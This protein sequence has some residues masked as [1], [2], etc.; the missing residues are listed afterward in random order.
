[1]TGIRV[2]R[3]GLMDTVQDAGRF[4]YYSLGVPDSGAADS[5]SLRAGNRILGNADSDAAI[6]LTLTGG[7]YEFDGDAD[8][9]LAGASM[10]AQVI[11]A[12]G[13]SRA[14]ELATHTKVH[15]GE[16]IRFAPATAGCRAYLCVR[17]GLDVPIVMGSRSTCLPGG[18]GGHEGRPLRAGD[19]LTIGNRAPGPLHLTTTDRAKAW[20]NERFQKR[21]LRVI[22]TARTESLRAAFDKMKITTFRASPHSD[23]GGL[24]LA[25]APIEAKQSGRMISEGVPL[26]AIQL[27]ESG[28]PI[29]LLQDRPTTGG[30]P[31]VACVI[32]ADIPAAAQVRPGENVSFEE[33]TIDA[34]RRAA[35]DQEAALDRSIP[36]MIALP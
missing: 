28:E 9:A 14:V 8:I 2:I 6:E 12:R 11:T 13:Q 5:L 22:R 31:I 36:P 33:I 24:R 10:P 23:R 20:Q 3:P 30:Y 1:M 21:P 29:I 19:L 26:G 35:R 17:G 32:E 15:A 16:S 25:G 34:A 7:V 27:P 4:G 18:F